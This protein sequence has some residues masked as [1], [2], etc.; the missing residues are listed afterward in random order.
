MVHAVQ[1]DLCNESE[2]FT[3]TFPNEIQ[4]VEVR[5]LQTAKTYL[6][7]YARQPSTVSVI[8]TLII[9]V[10]ALVFL[11]QRP[12]PPDGLVKSSDLEPIRRLV[13]T[14]MLDGVRGKQ[15]SRD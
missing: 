8:S 15:F 9:L 6:V 1:G 2:L 13:N 12:I 10:C 3:M 14:I 7:S 4:T 5:D 11:C